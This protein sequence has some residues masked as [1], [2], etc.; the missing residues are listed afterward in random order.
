MRISQGIGY[1]DDGGWGNV[2]GN[3]TS[4]NLA[5]NLRE[6]ARIGTLSLIKPIRA[7]FLESA[8]ERLLNDRGK[9]FYQ[10]RGFQG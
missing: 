3:R 8:L 9:Q 1:C 7:H 6:W 10:W 4:E 5:A 2:A